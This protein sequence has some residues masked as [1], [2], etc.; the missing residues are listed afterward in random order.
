MTRENPKSRTPL[1]LTL[2]TA[3]VFLIGAALIPLLVRGQANALDSSGIDLP[4]AKINQA[5]P[6][7][8]LTSLQGNAVSLDDMLG[9]VVLV[10]N[11]ATWCPPCQTEMPELQAYYKAHA[12]Q[13]F[14]IIAIESGE[15]ADA[16]AKFVQQYGLTFPVWLDPKGAALDS[17]NNRDLPSSYVIDRQ[18]SLRLSWTGPVTRATLEKYL[19]P[20][21]TPTE[22]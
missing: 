13:G 16:V 21:L 7:L 20:L 10:N 1:L 22:Q 19:T 14:V 4:P 12:G 17:F 18:G 11:W 3:G 8:A 5:A 2:L 6:K 15:S 9:K